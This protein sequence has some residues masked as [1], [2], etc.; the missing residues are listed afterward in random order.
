MAEFTKE[1][2]R[3]VRNL[4]HGHPDE[5]FESVTAQPSLNGG[6]DGMD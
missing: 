3:V 4:N 2:W 5:W 6:K 1:E